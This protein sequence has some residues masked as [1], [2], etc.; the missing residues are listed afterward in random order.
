M[1]IEHRPNTSTPPDED[2]VFS[3]I[4]NT[5]VAQAKRR[6]DG[7]VAAVILFNPG[8]TFTDATEMLD[9]LDHGLESKDVQN[10]NPDY[11][12]PVLWFV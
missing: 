11:G 2:G 6:P 10:F 1:T 8:V 4:M 3:R 9:S 7:Q 12:R 5:P